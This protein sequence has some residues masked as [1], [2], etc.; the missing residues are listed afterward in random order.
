[1]GG[2]DE[3]DEIP[4]VPKGDSGYENSGQYSVELIF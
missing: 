1:M 2:G 4:D 3:D